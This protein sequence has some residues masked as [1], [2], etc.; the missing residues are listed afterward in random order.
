MMS[1]TTARSGYRGIAARLLLA[2]LLALG[3]VLAAAGAA[4]GPVP[5]A[6]HP[7]SESENPMPCHTGAGQ[8]AEP[9]QPAC[10]HCSGDGPL[11]QCQC[12]DFAAPAGMAGL[13]SLPTRWP[14]DGTPPRSRINPPLPESP[15]DRL[16]RPPILQS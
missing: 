5:A 9:A 4:P 6:D 14:V 13:H 3:P 7:V 10:P 8:T 11:S 16:Y 2:W 1:E 15:G 12:C